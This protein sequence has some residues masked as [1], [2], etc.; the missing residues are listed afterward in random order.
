MQQVRNLLECDVIKDDWKRRGTNGVVIHGWVYQLEDVGIFGLY[1]KLI[2]Q[3]T[4]RDL[5]VSVGPPG[6]TTARRGDISNK[7]W[8]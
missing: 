3:G 8:V 1:I 7:A 5:N 2:L 4:V 6:H